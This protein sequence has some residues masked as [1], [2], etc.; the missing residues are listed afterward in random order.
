MSD[1]S[2]DARSD[3]SRQWIMAHVLGGIV[4]ATVP[5]ASDLVIKWTGI[6]AGH[7][8][9]LDLLVLGI[10]LIAANSLSLLILGYLSGVVLRQKLPLFPLRTWLMLYALFGLFVGLLSAMTWLDEE[11]ELNKMGLDDFTVLAVG[12]VAGGIL[13]ML[14]GATVGGLE[15]L[16]LRKTAEGLRTWVLY[17]ALASLPIAFVTVLMVVYGPLSGFVSEV[18]GAVAGFVAT[19]VGAFVMLPALHR[20]RPR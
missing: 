10:V 19:I 2:A 13:G 15:A 14:V 5:I 6:K 1:T 17:S 7:V 16:V 12:I 3:V 20:L 18:L 9:M 11:S 8:G 4:L